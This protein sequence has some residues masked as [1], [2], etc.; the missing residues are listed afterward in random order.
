[1]SGASGENQDNKAIAYSLND[2]EYLAAINSGDM[3]SARRMVDEAAK[4][5]G[6]P[7]RRYRGSKKGG[8]A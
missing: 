4:E 3:E 5:A 8:G 1:G 6:Y 2:E 7:E